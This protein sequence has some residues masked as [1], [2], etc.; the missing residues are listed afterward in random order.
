MKKKKTVY[1]N[2]KS[3]E[4]ISV[5]LFNQT[6]TGI[7]KG[8]NKNTGKI[9]FNIWQTTDYISS[10]PFTSHTEGYACFKIPTLLKT[11]KGTLIVFS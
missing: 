10:V 2:L 9:S 11:L 8:C 7:T 3:D 6:K 5:L 1:V 4:W